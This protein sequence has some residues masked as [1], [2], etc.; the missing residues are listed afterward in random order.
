MLSGALT[1]TVVFQLG[2]LQV[3]STTVTTWVIMLVCGL[4]AW[5]GSRRLRMAPGLF[6]TA[7]E[8]VVALM[9]DQIR[10]VAPQLTSELLPFIG[11]LWIF[12]LVAN[13]S[14]LLPGVASPTQDLSLTAA[15]AVVVFLSVHW[16]GI[17]TR[18][19]AAYFRHYLKPTPLLLPFEL[20]SEVTR[21]V[22]L[23]VRL[24]GNMMSLELTALLV[25]F[26][27]GFL[28]PIPILML[29]IVEAL[30]QAYIFGMLALIYVAGGLEAQAERQT[31]RSQP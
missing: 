29:H 19:A 31:E 22:S 13:L 28:V 18:G 21:T 30:V 25:L 16:F 1:A 11:T 9:E 2:P 3:T 4:L 27:A 12:L 7:V 24:F 8:A 14:G 20:I 17:R 23:A 26:V 10:Q 15:L 6:Q 5:A